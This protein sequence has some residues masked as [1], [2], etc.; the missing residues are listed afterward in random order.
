MS[1][2]ARLWRRVWNAIG[3]GS[4]SIVDDGAAVQTAQVQIGQVEI[5][6]SVPVAQLFGL[7]GNAPAGSHAVVLFVGGD[8]SNPIAIATN[9]SGSR[10]T[11]LLPGEVKVYS[12]F[13]SSIHLDASG[14][15]TVTPSGGQPV[16]VE[17]DLHVTGQVYEAY[18]TAAQVGLGTHI[19]AQG[20]DSHGDT[21]ADTSAP[22]A[23]T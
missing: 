16:T 6:D 7:S 10:P 23:G 1:D 19:H 13:G 12:A 5:H 15:I 8:R 21:E 14:G 20:N 9:H 2:A 3:F 4:L 18:G 22:I 11:G 17:G